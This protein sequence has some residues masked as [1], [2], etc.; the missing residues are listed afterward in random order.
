MVQYFSNIETIDKELVAPLIEKQYDQCRVELLKKEIN[1]RKKYCPVEFH[2]F[3]VLTQANKPK[4]KKELIEILQTDDEFNYSQ[5]QFVVE[6]RDMSTNNSLNETILTSEETILYT[7]NIS[8]TTH[9]TD[10]LGTLLYN[11]YQ[12]QSVIEERNMSNNSF[13]A[14]EE[15]ILYINNISNTTHVT[16]HLRTLLYNN[17]QQQ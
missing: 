17:Y 12:Q 8:N 6:E 13:L 7:N 16:D 1:F 14:N 9:V 5:Q 4:R 2:K 3:F 10:H 15:T 11:N